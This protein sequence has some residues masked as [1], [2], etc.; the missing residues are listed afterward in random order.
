MR[1]FTITMTAI[2]TTEMQR[3]YI[4]EFSP[5]LGREMGNGSTSGKP[6]QPFSPR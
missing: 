4:K 6:I 1:W 2:T 3:D 5:S